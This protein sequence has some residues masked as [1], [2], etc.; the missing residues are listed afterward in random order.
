MQPTLQVHC[1]AK[2]ICSV[3]EYSCSVWPMWQCISSVAKAVYEQCISG[4][5]SN[6]TRVLKNVNEVEG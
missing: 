4:E 6:Q 5:R 3:R 2:Y 1:S